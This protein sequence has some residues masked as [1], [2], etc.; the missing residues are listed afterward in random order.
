VARRGAA[1]GFCG[2]VET[3]PE[4]CRGPR[5]AA[6]ILHLRTLC[7]GNC[8]RNDVGVSGVVPPTG[9]YGTRRER[10]SARAAATDKWRHPLTS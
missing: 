7:Y 1:G 9:V 4:N 6:I 5:S 10:A 8:L 2:K 3:L